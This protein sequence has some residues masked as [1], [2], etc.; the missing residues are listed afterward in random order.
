MEK[1]PLYVRSTGNDEAIPYVVTAVQDFGKQV[2]N[3]DFQPVPW[4]DGLPFLE[5]YGKNGK[6]NVD[7]YKQSLWNLYNANKE[8]PIFTAE[9]TNKVLV[10]SNFHNRVHATS[11]QYCDLD[12]DNF[13]LITP[14]KSGIIVSNWCDFDN[15]Q[16]RNAMAYLLGFHEMGHLALGNKPCKSDNCVFSHNHG[17]LPRILESMITK[18]EMPICD[19]DRKRIKEFKER[20]G[21]K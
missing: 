14:D 9:T 6:V 2:L 10:P 15:E 5:R 8:T 17:S 4:V 11:A 19:F 13:E 1:T 16:Y 18:K 21:I 20:W 12:K 3:R 7:S